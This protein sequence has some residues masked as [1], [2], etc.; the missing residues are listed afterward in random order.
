MSPSGAW[1]GQREGQTLGGIRR[2]LETTED[3]VGMAGSSHSVPFIA[4]PP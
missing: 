2:I 3:I 1:G 4:H